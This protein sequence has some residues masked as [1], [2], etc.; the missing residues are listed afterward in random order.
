MHSSATIGGLNLHLDGKDLGKGYG[1]KIAVNLRML[2]QESRTLL[3]Y[4]EIS[5]ESS[6][7]KC[8]LGNR[9]LDL[10]L[11]SVLERG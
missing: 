7:M 2:D 9:V 1:S 4:N 11:L 8:G 3:N 5:Y 6:I 10:L